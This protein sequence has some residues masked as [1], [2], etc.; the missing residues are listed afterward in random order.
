MKKI[1]LFSLI[2]VLLPF[3]NGL[4]ISPAVVEVEYNESVEFN[5]TIINDISQDIVVQL[6][7]ESYEGKKDY[8]EYFVTESNKVE[9]SAGGVETL[10]FVLTFP[11]LEQFGEQR[12]A[13]IRF[14][15][16]PLV[17]SD[18]AATVAVLVPVKTNVPY[19]ETYVKMDLIAPEV[20]Q[21]GDEV[22]FS[23][24]LTH[25]GLNVIDEISGGFLITGEDFSDD[26]EID[27]LSLFMP[28]ESQTIEVSYDTI[29]LNPGRYNLSLKL[30]YDGKSKESEKV[31]LV[32]GEESVEILDLNPKD[33]NSNVVN[34][35][36]LT[37]FNLWVDYLDVDLSVDFIQDDNIVKSFEFGEY[38]L[39]VN[40]E[41]TISSG[42]DMS[43]LSDGDYIAK[44]K[45]DV[46]GKLVEKEFLV[47]LSGTEVKSEAAGEEVIEK[48]SYLIWCIAGGLI[49][50]AIILFVIYL[51]KRK[52]EED[53]FNNS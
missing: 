42:V 15:Q 32:V 8:S 52:N 38:T 3:V 34:T 12:F 4:L 30:E 26:V 7:Y 53:N 37:L 50:I 51:V 19:P 11:E 10:N 41:R 45:A 25:L 47:S 36:T 1:F 40:E 29:E 28:E 35:M 33:L 46:S 24:V 31:G 49:I 9:V 13:V 5:M 23:A 16:V 48:R 44:V 6:S 2:L 39:P 27:P 17:Q 14:Y 43:G 21:Q 18:M 22:L 20:V